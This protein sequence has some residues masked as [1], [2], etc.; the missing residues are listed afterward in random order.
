MVYMRPLF[1]LGWNSVYKVLVWAGVDVV[2]W[3]GDTYCLYWEYVGCPLVRV[4]DHPGEL[5]QQDH[6]Q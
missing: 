4:P 5:A 6:K 2:G 1:G 3:G